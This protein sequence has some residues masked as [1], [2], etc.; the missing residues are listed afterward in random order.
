[1]NDSAHY[2]GI[3]FSTA[4]MV[5]GTIIDLIKMEKSPLNGRPSVSLSKIIFIVVFLT[6]FYSTVTVNRSKRII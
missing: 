2:P 5:S 6:F 4:T 3:R 1:M